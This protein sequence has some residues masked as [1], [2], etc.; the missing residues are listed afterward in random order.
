[1]RIEVLVLRLVERRL[2]GVIAGGF[3][4]GIPIGH[5]RTGDHVK[6][7][8]F[9]G[10][11]RVIDG[12]ALLLLASVDLSGPAGDRDPSARNAAGRPFFLGIDR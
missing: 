2:H 3:I 9:L 8:A 5:R 6:A 7:R 4:G 1:M 11:L 10:E 12:L